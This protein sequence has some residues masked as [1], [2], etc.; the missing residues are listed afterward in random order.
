M[1]DLSTEKFI[2][3]RDVV[4]QEN[5]FAFSAPTHDMSIHQLS[6]SQVDEDWEI[7]NTVPSNDRGRLSQSKVSPSSPAV[8]ANTPSQEDQQAV[9]VPEEVYATT[10]DLPIPNVAP[11][12]VSPTLHPQTLSSSVEPTVEETLCRG[13]QSRLPSVKLKDYV[14]YNTARLEDPS[15]AL[16]CSTSPSSETIHGNFL[17][18]LTYYVTDAKFSA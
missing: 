17:Y 14:T 7:T 12:I 13:E 2:I 8:S 16:F 6:L 1:F 15:L 11:V 5:E 9:S 4:F 10:S 3:S 18:P